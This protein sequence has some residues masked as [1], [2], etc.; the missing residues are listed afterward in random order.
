[1][2]D[3][4][5]NSAVMSYLIKELSENEKDQI[6]KTIIQKMTYL[7]NRQGLAKYNFSMYHYGPYT[8]EVSCELENL[9][10]MNGINILW[11]PD[12]GYFI[13]P[14]SGIDK[15][16]SDNLSEEEKAKIDANIKKY[17]NFNAIEL[18]LIATA[19]YIRDNFGVKTDKELI[20]TVKS[21]KP[22]YHGRVENV[23]K[24][25]KVIH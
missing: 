12:N 21:L 24:K 5:K 22:Q 4:A 23:L 8:E 2:Q 20:E 25:S 6:G 14:T 15:F 10:N 3:K 11:K 13:Y 19:Y 17:L 7:L 9:R 1:M 16:I 18:S